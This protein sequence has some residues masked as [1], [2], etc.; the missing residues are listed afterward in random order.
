MK[1][2]NVL[3]QLITSA[4]ISLATTLWLPMRLL[5]SYKWL[6]IWDSFYLIKIL[7]KVSLG[8]IPLM[9]Q[10]V[11]HFC[12]E[13]WI[14]K[15]VWLWKELIFHLLMLI[16]CRIVAKKISLTRINK[17]ALFLVNLTQRLRKKLIKAYQV[18]RVK[19]L[20]SQEKCRK[21]RIKRK[22]C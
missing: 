10:S 12:K 11:Y 20:C 17:K 18:K 6:E 15:R 19:L 13:I 4:D 21:A 1:P 8:I 2:W 22:S 16:A 7:F 9:I 5:S 14:I 3:N